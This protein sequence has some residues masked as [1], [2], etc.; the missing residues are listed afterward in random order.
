[1]GCLDLPQG[2]ALNARDTLRI[3]SEARPSRLDPRYATDAYTQ[4]IIG[5]V[6]ASLARIGPDGDLEPYVAERWRWDDEVTCTFWLRDDFAFSDGHPLDAFDAE[7]TFASVLDPGRASPRRATL[8]SVTRVEAL[9]AREIRFHLAA[10]DAGFLEGTTLGIL[11]AGQARERAS[12]DLQILG[13]GPYR[14]A[15]IERD[16]SLR[17]APNPHY[18]RGPVAIPNIHVRVVPDALTRALELRRGSSDFVQSAIDPDTVDWLARVAPNV[19]VTRVPSSNVQYMGLN[20]RHPA[21]R[22]PRVRRALSS[23]IDRNAIVR[24]VLND[25]ARAADTLL[26][27]E[28]W[29]HTRPRRTTTY[30]PDV[31]RTLL[32]AAGLL[33]PDGDGPVARIVL[34]YKTTTDDLSRRI[35]ETIASQL[36]VVGIRL[37]IR[38]YDWGTFF[39][40][41][42]RGDFHLYSLQWVGIADPDLLRRILHSR[43]QPPMGNN[44][45]GFADPRIDRWTENARRTLDRTSRRRLYGRVER[46]VTRL[47][48]YIPLW[49][50]DRTIVSSKRLDGFRP[51]PGGDLTG[52]LDARLLDARRE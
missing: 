3:A 28:H 19:T 39:A 4:R 31:A 5:L 21:L 12:D 44:R 15:R 10:P 50:P 40:D 52:L 8:E 2:A 22:D 6:F 49:W 29:A 1:M 18:T 13:A 41:V 38:S 23:A 25:Q 7:E 37:E 16:G 46:R 27:P 48:P 9:N 42:Q 45:A 24:T 20:L 35:A 43:M 51:H 36:L 32:D 26:P 14:V 17:L 33:D 11:P 30:S 34:S 47:L